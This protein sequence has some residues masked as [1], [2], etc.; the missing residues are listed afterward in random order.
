MPTR[1]HRRVSLQAPRGQEHEVHF[2]SLS[3][4]VYH[5]VRAIPQR[6]AGEYGEDYEL[7]G[8]YCERFKVSQEP[9]M[10]R[11]LNLSALVRGGA[12]HTLR[13]VAMEI[14]LQWGR[15]LEFRERP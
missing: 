8:W 10:F 5:E 11:G 6:G 9:I 4:D 1:S 14:I 3:R 7:I 2:R 12:S 13:K 15:T